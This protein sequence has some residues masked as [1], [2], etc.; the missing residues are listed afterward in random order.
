M[1]GSPFFQGIGGI[2]SATAGSSG[3]PSMPSIGSISSPLSPSS[4]SEEDGQTFGGLL[5][6]AL[7]S[8]NESMDAAKSTTGALLSGRLDNLHEM[9]IASTKSGIMMKLTTNITSKLA[10]ATTQLFQMQI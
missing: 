10:Q 5:A 8:V 4:V 1:Q 9:T 6:N 7:G 3:I 2:G